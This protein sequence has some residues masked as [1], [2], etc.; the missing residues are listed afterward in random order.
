MTVHNF[1]PMVIDLCA[2]LI[3]IFFYNSGCNN[4]AALALFFCLKP[5]KLVVARNS[6]A[7]TSPPSMFFHWKMYVCCL[8]LSIDELVL[9]WRVCSLL[10]DDDVETSTQVFLFWR[11]IAA[12]CVM[13]SNGFVFSRCVKSWK[14]KP[15][16]LSNV[17]SV[18]VLEKNSF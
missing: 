9:G 12:L 8:L 14:V 3:S 5:S 6:C 16:H 11:L 17:L 1:L 13:A 2:F 7:C 10:H 15:L 4:I 18:S